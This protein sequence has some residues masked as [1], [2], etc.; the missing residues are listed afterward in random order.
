MRQAVIL[1]HGIGEPRPMA[2]LRRFV[3]GVLSDRQTGDAGSAPDRMSESYELRRLMDFGKRDRPGT[4]FFEY[5]WA[6]HMEGNT[7]RHVWSLVRVLLVRWPWTVPKPLIAVWTLSWVSI[8]GIAWIWIRI[9]GSESWRGT[10]PVAWALV[11]LALGVVQVLISKYLGDAARYLSPSPGNVG[12]RQKIRADGIAVVRRIHQSGKYDRVTIVGHSLGSVIGYDII[13]HL[14]DEMNT[15]H[16]Q[17]DRP[18]QDVLTQL[19]RQGKL[20]TAT[21]EEDRIAFRALQRKLWLEQRALGNPWLITDFITLG[22]PMTYGAILFARDAKELRRWQ[23]T[24]ELPTCPPVVSGGGY[25]YRPDPYLVNGQKRS[26]WILHHAAPFAVTRWTNIYV[27]VRLGIL[28]DWIG[29]P[30]K[31]VFGYGIR[32]VPLKGAHRQRVP[33][34]SHVTYWRKPAKSPGLVALADALDLDSRPW[35][36]R[37][38]PP[39]PAANP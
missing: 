38:I 24:R 3:E 18:K 23:D 35:L 9:L 32:D 21:S 13:T 25:S 14:W 37:S 26:V 1:I 11:S 22:S 16:A 2:T 15:V 10:R 36:P 39:L 20:L 28:G 33:L 17:L 34:L 27:P 4:D 5:Y 19:E 31:D 8:I 29:G 6:H 12:I 7:V 30:L